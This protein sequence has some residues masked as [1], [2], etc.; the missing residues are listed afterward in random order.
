MVS[1]G[2]TMRDVHSPNEHLYID[3]VGRFWTFLVALLKNAT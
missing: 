1:F 3:T 2:P